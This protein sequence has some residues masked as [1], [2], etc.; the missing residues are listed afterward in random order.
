MA[1]R[2]E[3]S[4]NTGKSRRRPATTPLG[5]ENELVAKAYSLAEEQIEEGTVSAQVLTHF[6]KAGSQRE[7]LER[8]KLRL[9]AELLATRKAA[10]ESATRT[11]E[12]YA[13][14]MKAMRGYSGMEEEP[15]DD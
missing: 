11:E 12:L 13:E 8:E 3:R 15:R 1:E 5:R 14:A 6:I 7:I 4:P 2:R 10:Y 9:E